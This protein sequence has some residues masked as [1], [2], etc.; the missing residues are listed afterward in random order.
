MELVAFKAA[1]GYMGKNWDSIKTQW[2]YGLGVN[3]SLGNAMN[4][5]LEALNQKNVV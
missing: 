5:R 4:N 3:A 2:L 1:D